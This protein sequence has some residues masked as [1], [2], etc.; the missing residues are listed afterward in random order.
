MEFGDPGR[1]E[2]LGELVAA[3]HEAIYY[4]NTERI[5]TALRM[6]PRQF[7]QKHAV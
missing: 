6:A 4:Y 1:Y 5:H 3:L 2:T 7:A